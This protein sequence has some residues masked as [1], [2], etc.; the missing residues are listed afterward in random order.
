MI[1]NIVI[2]IVAFIAGILLTLILSSSEKEE[3]VEIKKID[4]LPV[5]REEKNIR[6]I[7]V[8]HEIPMEELVFEPSKQWIEAELK[9]ELADAVWRYAIVTR[10]DN[11]RDFVHR[12]RMVLHVVD[13]GC[14]N[15]FCHYDERIGEK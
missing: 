4:P 7:F 1:E 14:M 13:H 3:V 2:A 15:P 11:Q 10:K 12:Y 6:Y 9:H 8:E 5:I